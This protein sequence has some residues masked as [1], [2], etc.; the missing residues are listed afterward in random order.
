MLSNQQQLA[1]KINIS[2]SNYF[3]LV[4]TSVLGFHRVVREQKSA[5]KFRHKMKTIILATI[6]KN[7]F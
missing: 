1:I 5:K 6:F 2:S 7:T 4:R 3:F